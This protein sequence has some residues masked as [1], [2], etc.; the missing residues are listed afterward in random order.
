MGRDISRTWNAWCPV[1][2]VLITVPNNRRVWRVA[3]DQ[4]RVTQA[5]CAQPSVRPSI[6]ASVFSFMS[7]IFSRLF[8]EVDK[9]VCQESNISINP[10][11]TPSSSL[12]RSP[13]TCCDADIKHRQMER[14]GDPENTF[15]SVRLTDISHGCATGSN[16]GTSE[17]PARNGSS[18]T[19]GAHAATH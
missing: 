16:P 17:R 14:G 19:R 3:V 12:P 15:A 13:P 18:A 5:V 8:I 7:P 10:S 4:T 6:F 11:R 1:F 9:R 2:C